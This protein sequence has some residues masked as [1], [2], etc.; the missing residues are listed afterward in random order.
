[1]EKKDSA[2]FERVDASVSFDDPA[3]RKIIIDYAWKAA[4]SYRLEIPGA[5]FTDIFQLQNDTFNLDFN[6]L[7]LA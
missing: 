5:A 2:I 3:L 6:N 7:I 4:G 1:M